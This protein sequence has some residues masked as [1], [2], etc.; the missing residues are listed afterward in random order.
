[1]ET[2]QDGVGR[3]RWPKG[4]TTAAAGGSRRGME[5]TPK[6]SFSWRA[7][8]GESGYYGVGADRSASGRA[9]TGSPLTSWEEWSGPLVS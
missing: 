2:G 9:E 6:T 4:V 7:E 5:R 8:R 3:R 1:M